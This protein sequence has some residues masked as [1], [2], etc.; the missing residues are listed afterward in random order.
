MVRGFRCS[1]WHWTWGSF[2][3][4][5]TPV[6]DEV[7]LAHVWFADEP[8][9]QDVL[10]VFAV[11]RSAILSFNVLMPCFRVSWTAS[12]LE[13]CRSVVRRRSLAAVVCSYRRWLH[14]VHVSVDSCHF[15]IQLFYSVPHLLPPVHF[16]F[17]SFTSCWLLLCFFIDS[18]LP[19]DVHPPVYSFMY[20]ISVEFAGPISAGFSTVCIM[21]VS[22]YMLIIIL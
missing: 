17:R 3:L 4:L 7:W 8:S 2:R 21:N 16:N 5:Q 20:A 22:S 18:L 12:S 14:V 10:P 9:A 1:E 15:C 11:I 13:H 6:W 19:H